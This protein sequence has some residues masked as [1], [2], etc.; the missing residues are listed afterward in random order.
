MARRNLTEPTDLAS[1]L[2]HAPTRTT[3]SELA[4]LAGICAEIV[5]ACIIIHLNEDPQ[6]RPLW[7]ASDLIRCFDIVDSWWLWR[8]R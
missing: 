3:P 6:D 1:Y 8:C 4:R 7:C 5:I 2:C